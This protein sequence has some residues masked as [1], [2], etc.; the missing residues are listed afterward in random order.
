MTTIPDLWMRSNGSF[1]DA[2]LNTSL[3]RSTQHGYETGLTTSGA[4]FPGRRSVRSVSKFA[5][6]TL[7]P[8]VPKRV[9][10]QHH[11]DR[12]SPDLELYA[13]TDAPPLH[14]VQES[15]ANFQRFI[16][17]TTNDG[18][19]F[20]FSSGSAASERGSIMVYHVMP[21][22]EFGWHV[23]L[24]KKAGWQIEKVTFISKAV[25]EALR[26]SGQNKSSQNN[27]V[28]VES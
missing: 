1:L 18:T 17:R 25:V 23:T 8:F 3:Q 13:Q 22:V 7:P 24:M 20:W 5:D 16:R 4:T 2:L 12:V 10:R 27:T 9:L 28:P 15:A 19:L 6:L 14:I 21:D 11:Y 26:K